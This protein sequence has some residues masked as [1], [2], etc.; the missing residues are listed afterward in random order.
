MSS[1]VLGLSPLAT[2]VELL[3][4]HSKVWALEMVSLWAQGTEEEME[5][6]L[7]QDVHRGQA[8]GV[9]QPGQCIDKTVSVF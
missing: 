6:L 9:E 8:L 5:G 2:P 1:A 4:D 3:A 7:S